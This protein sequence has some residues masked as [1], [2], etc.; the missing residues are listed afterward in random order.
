M[1]ELNILVILL[2][3]LWILY[4]SNK[5]VKINKKW[6]IIF[7]LS[8]NFAL[9]SEFYYNNSIFINTIMIAW[10]ILICLRL[11]GELIF[12]IIKLIKTK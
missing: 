11:L 8:T 3:T 5:L 2:N 7:L 6:I 4:V 12:F 10:F 9:I 1:T